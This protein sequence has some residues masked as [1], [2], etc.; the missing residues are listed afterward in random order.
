MTELQFTIPLDPKSKKNSQK[1]VTI[2]G[3]PRIVQGTAYGKY[4][5]LCK[6]FVPEL[7]RPIDYPVNVKCL[8][9]REKRLRVDLPNLLAAIDDILVKYGVLSDDNRDIVA[10]H[11]GST[12]HWDKQNPRTE[13][14]ITPLTDYTQ[15]GELIHGQEDKNGSSTKGRASLRKR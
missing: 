3:R 13:V 11:D 10:S 4:E 1:I 7:A 12:V 8:F 14:T 15:W 5:K 9:Y 6:E 2:C